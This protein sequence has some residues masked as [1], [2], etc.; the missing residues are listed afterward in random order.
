MSD[1]RLHFELPASN[2][3]LGFC[4]A[5]AATVAEAAEAAAV[6]ELIKLSAKDVHTATNE[7]RYTH[8][9]T[10]TEQSPTH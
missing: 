6:S 5:A 10:H 9:H 4:P 1:F 2:I 3:A 7:K 8:T